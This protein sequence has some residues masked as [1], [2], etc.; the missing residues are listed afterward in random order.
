MAT[1]KPNLTVTDST[2]AS[3]VA[4]QLEAV[5]ADLA[6]LT[7]TMASFASAK[8]ADA[9][10]R[11]ASEAAALSESAKAQLARAQAEGERV[12]IQ[13]G[14]MIRERPGTAVG[15]AAAVGFAIGYLSSRR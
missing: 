1:T 13:T 2:D 8:G 11:V 7:R 9:R 4:A 14:D 15:I 3:D 6:E 12:A 10:A 5:K